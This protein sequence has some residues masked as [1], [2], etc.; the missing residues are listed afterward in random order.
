[1]INSYECVNVYVYAP[2]T[3]QMA[4]VSISL[5]HIEYGIFVQIGIKK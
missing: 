4:I 5:Q 1:M 2:L 3:E